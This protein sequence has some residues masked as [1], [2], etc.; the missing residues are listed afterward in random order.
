MLLFGSVSGSLL[1][2]NLGFLGVVLGAISFFCGSV[3]GLL[4]GTH[5]TIEEV[6]K[7]IEK[8]KREL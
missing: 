2:S 5:V 6:I 4:I 8:T 3:V 1:Y 7:L